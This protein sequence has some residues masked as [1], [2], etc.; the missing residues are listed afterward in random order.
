MQPTQNEHIHSRWPGASDTRGLP[1]LH[2]AERAARRAARPKERRR[3]RMLE[4]SR[5][6]LQETGRRKRLVR[7]NCQQGMTVARS[8]QR[9]GRPAGP[10]ARR[11]QQ[12]RRTVRRLDVSFVFL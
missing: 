12:E 4:A 11:R 8:G 3:K 1:L 6:G 7:W 2:T 10:A 5:L 9:W